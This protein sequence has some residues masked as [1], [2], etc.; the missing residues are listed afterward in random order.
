MIKGTIK[1][2]NSYKTV[3]HHE[4]QRELLCCHIRI[5]TVSDFCTTN[6]SRYLSLILALGL[7]AVCLVGCQA[8]AIR[9]KPLEL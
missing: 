3:Q 4:I 1:P 7:V 5:Y 9:G 6:D 2:L 8:C